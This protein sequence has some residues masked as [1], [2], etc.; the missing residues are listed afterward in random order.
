M[1]L[2]QFTEEALPS[3]SFYGDGSPIELD[4]L[5]TLRS[6]YLKEKVI[7]PWKTNNVLALDNMLVAHGR[8]PYSGERKVLVAMAQAISEGNPDIALCQPS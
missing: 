4:V 3:N 8:E 7:F 1:L 5:D 6:A 2:S